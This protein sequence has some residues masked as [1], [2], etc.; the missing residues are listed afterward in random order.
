M[1]KRKALLLTVA[2]I[3]AIWCGAAA[4]VAAESATGVVAAAARPLDEPTIPA[5]PTVPPDPTATPTPDPVTPDVLALALNVGPQSLCP[6]YNLYYTLRI[7]NTS[8]VAPMPS[9][10]ITQS[11][12]LG[13]WYGGEAIQGTL[14]GSYVAGD[15]LLR[16][17]VASL[18]P[19][20]S[21]NT[22]YLLHTYSSLPSGTLITSTF[23]YTSPAL[24][25]SGLI[26][27]TVTVNRSACAAT[28]TPTVTASPTRTSTPTVTPT[29]T[30]T[31]VKDRIAYLPLMRK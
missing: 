19:G 30:A 10:V 11:L 20:Q 3:A 25:A 18:A 4:L 17:S 22:S 24:V 15:N 28:A 23:V 31:S 27:D 29:A 12:P 21:L 13:T 26:S 2:V 6:G 14:P 9:L 16:W 5:S 8:S 1:N 7:T